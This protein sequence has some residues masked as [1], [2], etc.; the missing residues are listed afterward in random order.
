MAN[1]N[2]KTKVA[3][4]IVRWHV[5]IEATVRFDS[6]LSSRNATQRTTEKNQ[7]TG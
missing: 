3:E 6:C 2:R 5:G 7:I 4:W 1:G